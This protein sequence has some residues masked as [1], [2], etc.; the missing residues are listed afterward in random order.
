ME[1]KL[2]QS[3]LEQPENQKL[4]LEY[5]QNPNENIKNAIEERFKIHVMKIKIL[6]YFSKV[7]YFEAQKFDKKIRENSLRH[8][9]IM[10]KGDDGEWVTYNDVTHITNDVLDT[11]DEGSS[12]Q[13][14]KPEN[15]LEDE[16][17][18]TLVAN[19]SERSKE[20]LYL[21]YVKELDE[22]EVASFLN[23]SKQAVNK[24]KNNLLKKIRTLYE[25]GR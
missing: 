3:F 11:F 14:F 23:V 8:A 25:E 12:E 24:R 15:L 5:L 13:N 6:S 21:L 1:N 2:L 22:G 17:L 7:F 9:L 10:D 20:L 19:L 16:K 4:Y 18:F